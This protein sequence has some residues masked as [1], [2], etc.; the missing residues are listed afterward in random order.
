MNFISENIISENG[1]TGLTS[2]LNLVV[3]NTI[4]ATTFYGDGS[5]LTNITTS[6]IIT[7]SPNNSIQFNNNNSLTGNSKFIYSGDTLFFTG[8]SRFSGSFYRPD[9]LSTKLKLQWF[10]TQAAGA[11]PGIVWT[12]MPLALST[13]LGSSGVLTGDATYI[14]DLTEYSQY[15]FF[16]S[17]Q[18]A[19]VA[20]SKLI[21]QS[22]L[23]NSTWF[24]LADVTVG[25]GTGV[26]DSNWQ[27]IPTSANTFNYIRLVGSGGN[28]TADPRFSPPI[29]L[30]R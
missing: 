30:F 14:V 13:W 5:N 22:S 20:G 23:N 8:T 4:S 26:R 1:F 12:N 28:G 25:T 9:S 16:F 15:R 7:T 2:S 11:T 24:T 6:N 27:S 29:I 19:G 18:V 21:V 3:S 17:Q 10:G